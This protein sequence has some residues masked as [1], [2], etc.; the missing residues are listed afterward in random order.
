MATGAAPVNDCRLTHRCLTSDSFGLLKAPLQQDF[1]SLRTENSFVDA[2]F[3]R[4]Q[5][6]TTGGEQG[7]P[8]S[9]VRSRPAFKVTHG[10]LRGAT[11]FDKTKPPQNV[12]W[13]LGAEM[14]DERHKSS[15][16][17]YDI[18]GDLDDQGQL[19]PQPIDYK[20]L[21]LDRRRWDTQSFAADLRTDAD[22]LL[23]LALEKERAAGLLAGVPAR[24][25]VR[26]EDDFALV[27]VAVSVKP[28][29]GPRSGHEFPLDQRRFTLLQEGCREAAE[30]LGCDALSDEIRQSADVPGGLNN[31]RAFGLLL[32][33][34]SGPSGGG[35]RS[36]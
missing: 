6:D 15:R 23:A 4:R 19:M 29:R 13:L 12:V 30:R 2:F 31:E 20:R 32:G 18:L 17:A 36:A 14:H 3:D 27:V 5:N 10:R 11:W 34:R 24:W 8:V 16:D 7:E 26:R 25:S 22:E 33:L 9:R 28:T 1:A 35:V 21:E